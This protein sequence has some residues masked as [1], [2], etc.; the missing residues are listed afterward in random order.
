M[1][2]PS[3]LSWLH[4]AL[5]ATNNLLVCQSVAWLLVVVERVVGGPVALPDGHHGPD[6][7]VDP[8]HTAI[9]R[10]GYRFPLPLACVDV[11]DAQT[12][13][14]AVAHPDIVR[15]EHDAINWVEN[16]IDL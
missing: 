2:G 13:E 10:G 16:Q 15:N 3:V 1:G 8:P 14:R 4:P 7:L 9:G 11:E 5:S 6:V 12:N